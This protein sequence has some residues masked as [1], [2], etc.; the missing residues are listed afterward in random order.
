MRSARSTARSLT[1]A[2]LRGRVG[3]DADAILQLSYMIQRLARPCSRRPPVRRRPGPDAQPA[4]TPCRLT[5]IARWNEVAHTAIVNVFGDVRVREDEEVTG[6][7]VAVL[8]SVR[9]DGAV[10]DQVVAVLGS[11]EL[12]PKAVVRGDIISV[13]G[14][15]HLVGRCAGAR[16]RDGSRARTHRSP[17]EMV[18]WLSSVGLFSLGS[19]R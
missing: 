1:G 12:G 16:R 8:G 7:V 6:Q 19:L 2:E 17:G 4:P 10:G 14:R 5:A 3:S 9:I 13:G 15:V 11:V 18:P